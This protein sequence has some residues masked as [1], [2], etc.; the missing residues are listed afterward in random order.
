MEQELRECEALVEDAD[1]L[2]V[3]V[4]TVSGVPDM[5][6]E[7]RALYADVRTRLDLARAD[8]F[9][10]VAVQVRISCIYFTLIFNP[11]CLIVGKAPFLPANDVYLALTKSYLFNTFIF[12]SL[13]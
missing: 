9:G 7:Y 12:V 1:R 4:S 10:D 13:G 8:V 5:V 3:A 2:S 11:Y 6:A